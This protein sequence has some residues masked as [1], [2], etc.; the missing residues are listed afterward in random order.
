[1]PA[2]N[3]FLRLS[4]QS[5]GRGEEEL[6]WEEEEQSREGEVEQEEPGEGRI[7]QYLITIR[8]PRLDVYVMRELGKCKKSLAKKTRTAAKERLEAMHL[9]RQTLEDKNRLAAE[10]EKRRQNEN[11]R[12][13]TSFGTRA[14]QS[15]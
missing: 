8:I 14:F 2:E 6:V 10:N 1:M 13:M 11:E 3:R 12:E 7:H 15:G 9:W 4:L 5:Q